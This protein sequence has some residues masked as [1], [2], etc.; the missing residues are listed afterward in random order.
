[1]REHVFKMGVLPPCEELDGVTSGY[2]LKTSIETISRYF[3]QI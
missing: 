3:A 2:I 1:M